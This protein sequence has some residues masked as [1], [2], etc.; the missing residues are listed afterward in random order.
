M[1][2]NLLKYMFSTNGQNLLFYF[3]KPS[4]FMQY[5]FTTHM[6]QK[7]GFQIVDFITRLCVDYKIKISLSGIHLYALLNKKYFHP[8]DSF[9]E[10]I[11]FCDDMENI[12]NTSNVFTKKF[13]NIIYFQ[14]LGVLFICPDNICNEI[15]GSYFVVV[16]YFCLL[17][18]EDD[19]YYYICDD[20]LS[21]KKFK[22]QNNFIQ[23]IDFNSLYIFSVIHDISIIWQVPNEEVPQKINDNQS[24]ELNVCPLNNYVYHMK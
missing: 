19:T 14:E 12:L 22:N 1:N 21:K 20:F 15:G 5:I 7:C 3:L 23:L 24:D 2:Y 18:K 11:I 13:K 16:I 6:N 17:N 4:Q 8:Y 10:M 9:I